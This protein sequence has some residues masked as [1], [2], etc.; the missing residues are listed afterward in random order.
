MDCNR[1]KMYN[2]GDIVRVVSTNIMH[3]GLYFKAGK[4]IGYKND[5][6]TRPVVKLRSGLGVFPFFNE[7][8]AKI[9]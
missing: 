5:D 4:V 3:Y 1:V 7:D 6:E 2:I 9:K 8:L